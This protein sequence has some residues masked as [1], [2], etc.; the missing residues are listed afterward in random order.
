MPEM[1]QRANGK[2]TI[3]SDVTAFCAQYSLPVWG[4]ICAFAIKIALA[5]FTYGT[6]DVTTWTEDLAVI[7]HDGVRMLYLSGV[8]SVSHD[9]VRYPLQ[10]FSHPP[11]MVHVLQFWGAL[12]QATHLPLQFWMRFTCALCDLAGLP[13][14]LWLVSCSKIAGNARLKVL[15]L[16]LACCNPLSIMISGFHGNTDPI[17]VF[18]LLLSVYCIEKKKAPLMAGIAMGLALAIKVVPVILAPAI[19]FYLRRWSD[20]IW[21]FAAVLLVFLGAGWPYTF[22]FPAIILASIS[23]YSSLP[24]IWS[25]LG[26]NP[27]LNKIVLL[28]AI[29]VL[30]YWLNRDRARLPLFAQFG[31]LFALFLFFG[32]GFAIQ[33]LAW[34]TPWVVYLGLTASSVFYL[35]SSVYLF[36]AYTTWS[37]GLPWY[38]ADSKP[39]GASGILLALICW[40]VIGTTLLLFFR[41]LRVTK[42]IAEAH[43]S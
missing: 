8:Q 2:A 23:R 43:H 21:F 38:F 30:S 9:G 19:F 36:A 16:T 15:L 37:G 20:R 40:Y 31:L 1:V 4:A 33:Y 22:Q 7:R 39:M 14:L 25:I 17:M 3:F 27:A 12:A 26:V 41:S 5:N 28:T 10:V 34:M 35:A 24:G 6:N 13:I 29:T 18:F 32:P 11:S 42:Q